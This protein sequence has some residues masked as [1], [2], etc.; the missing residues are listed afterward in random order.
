MTKNPVALCQYEMPSGRQCRQIA[1]KSEQVCRHHVRLF[2]RSAAEML[3]EEAMDRLAA[4]L[5]SLD[6]PTLLRT[7]HQSLGSIDRRIRNLPATHLTLG[8]VLE[9][10]D[11]TSPNPHEQ[12]PHKSV[13]TPADSINWDNH[14][15]EKRAGSTN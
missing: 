10:L 12:D 1:L 15:F 3:H 14:F 11:P 7:L 13:E 5:H 4:H 2:R 9:R 6:T 8:I